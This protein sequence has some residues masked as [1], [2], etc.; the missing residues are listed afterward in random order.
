MVV[1][2]ITPYPTDT[3]TWAP[4][5]TPVIIVVTPTPL[6][7]P[8]SKPVAVVEAEALNVRGGPGMEYDVLGQVKQGDKLEIVARTEKG[9]WLQ[10]RL[11]DGKEGWV[12]AQLVEVGGGVVDIPVA[13]VIPPTPTP[14]APPGMVYVPAGEFIMGSTDADVDSALALCNE[15]H[16]DCPRSWFEDEQPQH[17][18]YLD[19]FYIDKAEVT[20]AQ[21][22]QFLNEQ[23]NQEEGGVTWL[24]I[25]DENCRI[26][27]SGG[28]YQ[29]KSGYGDHPGIEVSSYGARAYCK[30]LGK[31]LPTEA[32]WEK[33][34][35][36]TDGRTYPWGNAS[37][38]SRVNFCDRNCKL[39]CKNTGA[40]DGYAGTAPVGSYPAGVSPYGALDMAGNVWEWVADWYDSGYYASSPESNPKGAASGD[41]RVFRG[42]SWASD[43]AFVRAAYR[44][45]LTPGDTRNDVG[46][47]CAR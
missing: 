18:V 44:Y 13:V 16:S 2:T 24:D 40:D 1:P 36:G 11:T 42:G 15:Y 21:F 8:T 5:P 37:D 32:E 14:S 43:A 30:W 6:A 34:A 46:F 41:Y 38:G 3:P 9:D 7:T 45:R 17:T 20:N 10:V 4:T 29:P 23:G 25:G 26:T 33:A 39:D 12:S 19:A 27:E 47:R 31:R 28:Q 35:R 22:A